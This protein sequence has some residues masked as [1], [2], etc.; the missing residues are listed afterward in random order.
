MGKKGGGCCKNE[1]RRG[2]T[3]A[4]REEE[5][6]LGFFRRGGSDAPDA[7]DAKPTTQ[8]NP[9]SIQR[10]STFG[11]QFFWDITLYPP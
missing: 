10:R 4:M 8:P 7:L 9:P 2:A 5:G 11:Q 3:A 6:R 1:G